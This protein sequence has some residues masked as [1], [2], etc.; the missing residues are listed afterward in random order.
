MKTNENT[1]T[2]PFIGSGSFGYLASLGPRRIAGH[3][4]FESVLGNQPAAWDSRWIIGGALRQSQI[5]RIH[6]HVAM[7]NRDVNRAVGTQSRK[8]SARGAET[9]NIA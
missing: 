4:L 5:Y 2:L 1:A 7:I 9:Q 3:H 6:I 8:Y